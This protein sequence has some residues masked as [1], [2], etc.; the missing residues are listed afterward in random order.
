MQLRQGP[1]IVVGTPGRVMDLIRR[2]W[3]QLSD[4]RYVVLDEADEMLSLGFMEDVEWI[5]KKTPSGRQTLLFSATMP[6]ADPQA[7]RSLPLR[8][9][10]REGGVRD[11][12]RRDDRPGHRRGRAEPQAGRAV[13]DPRARPPGR[14]DRV[15]AAQDDRRRA[16]RPARRARLRRRAAARRHAPG[17]SRR[18][19]AAVPQR[20][21][22]A[23]RGHQRRGPRP[24]HLA[25]LA[26]LL[27]R[28]A[29]RSRRST[30]TASGAP[31]ASG[32]AASR[33]RS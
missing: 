1:Q 33:T 2:G 14:G 19:D 5:L 17:P 21:R 13:R 22:E 24:R 12:D 26:R 3:L 11:A 7:R 16:R 28:R 23:A 29:G 20:A 8:A 32:A 9:R 18:R 31:G 4:A 10:A 27:L 30:R 15:P 25:R 6:R